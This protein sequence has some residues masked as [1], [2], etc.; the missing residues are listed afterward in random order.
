[1]NDAAAVDPPLD[2]VGVIAHFNTLPAGRLLLGWIADRD[3]IPGARRAWDA[4]QRTVAI[5][6]R[7]Y[8]QDPHS[9]RAGRD[10]DTRLLDLHVSSLRYLMLGLTHRPGD[11]WRRLVLLDAMNIVSDLLYE[12]IEA[13]GDRLGPVAPGLVYVVCGGDAG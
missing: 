12:E 10:A 3:A 13:I 9:W 1:V 5:A 8:T 11:R 6:W 7:Q 2:L 4:Y